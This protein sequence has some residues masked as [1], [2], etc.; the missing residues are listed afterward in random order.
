MFFRQAVRR[1][2]CLL[3]E[4]TMRLIVVFLNLLV[5]MSVF[6]QPKDVMSE[7][8]LSATKYAMERRVVSTTYPDM[9]FR[10]LDVKAPVEVF[11]ASIDLNN[12]GRKD[13]VAQFVGNPTCGTTGCSTLALIALKDGGWDDVLSYVNT[14]AKYVGRPTPNTYRPLWL[15]GKAGRTKWVF[16]GQKYESSGRQ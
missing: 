5:A 10:Q 1:L 3:L 13:I 12:D 15:T 14:H 11:V 6:A 16:N 8:Q 7:L 9:L 2:R 4:R